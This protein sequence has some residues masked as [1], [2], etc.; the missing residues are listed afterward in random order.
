[1][2][3]EV[4]CMDAPRAESMAD[5]IAPPHDPHAA[6]A[7]HPLELASIWDDYRSAGGEQ[8]RLDALSAADGACVM[9]NA[10]SS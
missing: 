5:E 1:M 6:A 4:V 8:E 9:T 3:F 10:R 7:L 2:V